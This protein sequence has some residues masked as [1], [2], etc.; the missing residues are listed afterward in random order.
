MAIRPVDDYPNRLLEMLEFLAPDTVESPSAAV[1]TPG[2]FNSAYFEHSFLAQQ[3][4]VPLVE[5]RDLVVTDGF[6]YMRTTRGFERLDVLYRRIDDDF[7]DPEAFNQ[8]SL[9]GVPGIMEVYRAGRIAM[10]N[11]PGTGIADDKAVY[12]YVPEIIKFYLGEEA[13]L[14]NVPTYVCWKDKDKKHVL[15]NLD[16][17]VVKSVDESGGYGMLIGPHASQEERDEFAKRIESNPR[18]YIAQSTLDLSRAPTIIDGGI[19]GRHVDLRPYILYGKDIYVHPGGL[20]RVALRKGSLVVNSSQ[21]GGSKD[22]WV[23][24]EVTN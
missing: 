18:K 1:L 23:L 10:A 9:L 4:G 6:V 17:L 5:G 20:T 24:E 12:A 22:T 21:G 8:D 13:I 19:E 11:A 2:I 3:M 16:K 7:L 14:P 15:Q